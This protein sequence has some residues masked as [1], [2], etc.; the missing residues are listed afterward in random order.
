MLHLLTASDEKQL[1]Q[2]LVSDIRDTESTPLDRHWLV[3]ENHASKSWLQQSLARELGI[4]AGFDFLQPGSLIWRTLEEAGVDIPAT[5][6]F[7][8]RVLRWRVAA[9]LYE[10]ESPLDLSALMQA[11]E[12]ARV[13]DRYLH[14]RPKLM[15]HWAQRKQT[16]DPVAELWHAVANQF[17][18]QHPHVLLDKIQP[19]TAHARQLEQ[20]LPA[21]IRIFNPRQL[22][23][24][25]LQAALVLARFRPVS[26][27]I[28]NP[29]PDNFWFDIKDKQ[30]QLYEKLNNPALFEYYDGDNLSPLLEQL[31][32]Q[33][34][35][36]LSALLE[37]EGM[38]GFRHTVIENVPQNTSASLQAN[39]TLLTSLRHDLLS[40]QPSPKP[41]PVDASIRIHACHSRRRELEVARDDI[42]DAIE[43]QGLK[44]AKILVLAPDINDYSQWIEGVFGQAMA[45]EYHDPASATPPSTLSIRI[46]WHIDRMH[47]KDAPAPAALL[48]LLNALDGRLSAPD[49]IDL[50]LHEP[51]RAR[52]GIELSDLP[53]LE[54]WIQQSGVCWGQDAAHR[55]Q[56]G[57]YPSQTNTWAFGCDRWVAGLLLGEHD[58]SLDVLET[59]GALEGDEAVFAGF[60]DFLVRLQQAHQWWQG[61]KNTGLSSTEWLQGLQGLI[62]DFMAD[63]DVRG[64]EKIQAELHKTLLTETQKTQPQLFPETV[65]TLVEKALDKGEYHSVGEIGVRFQSWDNACLGPAKMVFVMGM[66]AGE[67]PRN[68]PF[69]D[70]DITRIQPAPLDKNRRLNDKDLL[71]ELL[72]EPLDRVAF[73]Y[74]GF[75]PA[76]NMELAPSNLLETLLEYLQEKTQ[77]N[78]EKPFTIIKHKMHGFHPDYFRQAENNK[79]PDLFSYQGSACEQA[80]QICHRVDP[81]PASTAISA[82]LPLQEISLISLEELAAFFADPVK[83]FLRHCLPVRLGI[84]D[85]TLPD[86][87]NWDLQGLNKY[88]AEKLVMDFPLTQAQDIQKL[89]HLDGL[90]PDTPTGQLAASTF[91]SSMADMLAIRSQLRLRPQA[92]EWRADDN[93]PGVVRQVTGELSITADGTLVSVVPEAGQKGVTPKAVISHWL[94]HVFFSPG[95]ESWLVSSGQCFRFA[96]IS[97][98]DCVQQKMLEQFAQGNQSPWFVLPRLCLRVNKSGLNILDKTHYLNAI[99]QE[100]EKG[101]HWHLRH[102]MDNYQAVDSAQLSALHDIFFQPLNECIAASSWPEAEQ[103]IVNDLAKGTAR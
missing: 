52:F 64:L 60:F 74:Q 24:V 61:Q 25:Q 2:Q 95:S 86:T 67:F 44:P 56:L 16:G 66:N 51:L 33:K 3:V 8:A 101:Y 90:L 76:D 62:R 43:N 37:L 96:A 68:E 23:P 103:N 40:N 35:G 1:G 79:T 50:L 6:Q 58:I 78:A 5:P 72:A 41:H 102:F 20:Q 11:E 19:G 29:S 49:V 91:A 28:T 47:I 7:D 36:L 21:S 12:F 69:S 4:C 99:H 73:S 89:L 39:D 17:G 34:A 98:P 55:R 9:C 87:E 80:R 38:D 92:F 26:I 14:Y 97:R 31:G 93:Q 22:S 70:M 13:M 82:R 10:K 46:P 45:R 88:R 15:Q 32:R 42:L 18:Q 84:A 59:Y 77:K 27:Y 85:D 65:L 54:T 63:C 94:G 30:Q 53:R 83:Y 71:L 81:S 100:A 57:F 75:S 48:A